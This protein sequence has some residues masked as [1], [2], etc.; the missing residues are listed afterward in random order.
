MPIFYKLLGDYRTDAGDF[1][2]RRTGLGLFCLV[3][4]V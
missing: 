2:W 4:I 1:V 3:A